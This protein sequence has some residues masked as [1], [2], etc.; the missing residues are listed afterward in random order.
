MYA[1]FPATAKSNRRGRDSRA[2]VRVAA[3][4]AV[5]AH[6][7]ECRRLRAPLWQRHARRVAKLDRCH[8]VSAGSS[9]QRAVSQRNP[10]AVSQRGVVSASQTESTPRVMALKMSCGQRTTQHLRSESNLGNRSDRTSHRTPASIPTVAVP[11]WAT[12]RPKHLLDSVQ[13]PG[14]WPRIR[15]YATLECVRHSATERNNQGVSKHD[16][17]RCIFCVC[18]DRIRV[19]P[20]PRQ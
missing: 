2:A 18:P 7:Q 16:V 4:Q 15:D 14:A 9:N 8:G 10:V 1:W 20:L 6:G 3:A 17:R 19:S 12:E 13:S 5:Q 11:S